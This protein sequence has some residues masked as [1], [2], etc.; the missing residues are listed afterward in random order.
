MS[1]DPVDQLLIVGG[2]R[3]GIGT[4][5]QVGDEAMAGSGRPALWIM[6]RNL[7]AAPIDEHLLA[8][9]VLLTQYLVQFVDPALIQFAETAV[10]VVLRIRLF[11]FFPQ[12]LQSYMP[13]P[14]LL[15]VDNRQIG[16]RLGWVGGTWLHHTEQ[17]RLQL[18]VAPLFR[19]RPCD[20]AALAPCK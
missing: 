3:V 19:Q 13:V 16:C 17:G 2:L 18:L 9:L 5:V 15:L 4:G 7:R 14:L 11:V 8:G 12:Q 6:D 20:P 10:A 1:A